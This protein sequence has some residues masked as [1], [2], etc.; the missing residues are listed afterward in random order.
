MA[1]RYEKEVIQI[2]L[3]AGSDGVVRDATFEGCQI[4]GPAVIAPMGTDFKHNTFNA[5][6]EDALLWELPPDRTQ[7]VGAVAIEGGSFL[8][9]T[10]S[11]V[12]IVGPKELLDGF[13]S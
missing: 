13:R 12:G 7:I 2:A 8:G 10:F 9:C 3:L 5:A 11:M 6:S 4:N 1:E